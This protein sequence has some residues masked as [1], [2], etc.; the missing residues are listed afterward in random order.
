MREATIVDHKEDPYH[1]HHPFLINVT[2]LPHRYP[3][4]AI[5][6]FEPPDDVKPKYPETQ[7]KHLEDGF[8]TDY[9]MLKAVFLRRLSTKELKRGALDNVYPKDI[10]IDGSKTLTTIEKG[11][12]HRHVNKIKIDYNPALTE[13]DADLFH[14]LNHLQRLSLAHNFIKKIKGNFSDIPR[15]RLLNLVGNNIDFIDK[16]TFINLNKLEYLCLSQNP[17]K[18]VT[19]NLLSYFGDLKLFSI[20]F[21]PTTNSY[22]HVMNKSLTTKQKL[23]EL[24]VQGV[25]DLNPGQVCG[26]NAELLKISNGNLTTLPILAGIICVNSMY[27][28][29]S[30][31]KLI[32]NN[33][34]RSEGLFNLYE[35]YLDGNSIKTFQEGTFDSLQNLGIL[36]LRRNSISTIKQNYF[37]NLPS[38]RELYL[39]HNQISEIEYGTFWSLTRIE[40]LS[41][42]HNNIHKL[43]DVSLKGS[44]YNDLLLD[45]SYNQVTNVTTNFLTEFSLSPNHE[46]TLLLR[47]NKIR[48]VQPIP[49]GMRINKLDL[50]DN[51]ISNINFMPYTGHLSHIDFSNNKISTIGNLALN[52][53]MRL[54]NITLHHNFLTKISFLRLINRDLSFIDL[55][56][57]NMSFIPQK[58]MDA[59]ND[60]GN[61]KISGNPW[62][63]SCNSK[64]MKLTNFLLDNHIV[65]CCPKGCNYS[66]GMNREVDIN[67]H[68]KAMRTLP[69]CLPYNYVTL[70]YSRNFLRHLR[71]SKDQKNIRNLDVSK[72]AISKIDGSSFEELS[73]LSI[74]NLDT[75]YLRSIPKEMAQLR[76]T[77]IHI[78]NNPF[79]CRDCKLIDTLNKIQAITPQTLTCQ[80]EFE[81]AEAANICK[82]IMKDVPITLLS[83]SLITII[84]ALYQTFIFC[85]LKRLA[86]RFTYEYREFDG[87]K[88]EK[89]FKRYCEAWQSLD[90]VNIRKLI[91]YRTSWLPNHSGHCFLETI[92]FSLKETHVSII[93]LTRSKLS[94]ELLLG[95][96]YLHSDGIMIIHN[97]ISIDTIYI[98]ASGSQLT[99]KIGD[100]D[101]ARKRQNLLS[102]PTN[103]F[104]P[105][106][107]DPDGDDEESHQEEVDL[108]ASA[109]VIFYMLTGQVITGAV[110]IE[111]LIDN[112]EVELATVVLALQE[113]MSASQGVLS[114]AFQSFEEK[115]SLLCDLNGALKE[116]RRPGIVQ[117][118]KK[119]QVSV[120]DTI[121]KKAE[122]NTWLVMGKTDAWNK[123]IHEEILKKFAL[124]LANYKIT[125]YIDLL[126]MIRNILQHHKENP[127]A[128]MIALNV[129]SAPTIQEVLAYFLNLFPH[130]YPHSFCC[131]FES[132]NKDEY[133]GHE[134]YI[135][136]YQKIENLANQMMSQNVPKHLKQKSEFFVCFQSV[137][138]APHWLSVPENYA[139]VKN[140]KSSIALSEIKPFIEESLTMLWPDLHPSE[141]LVKVDGDFINNFFTKDAPSKQEDEDT[142]TKSATSIL[143]G[144]CVQVLRPEIKVDVYGVNIDIKI[145]KLLKVKSL[146]QIIFS[147][148]H[149]PQPIKV[150]LDKNSQSAMSLNKKHLKNHE[151][152]HSLDFTEHTF[153]IEFP[154][155]SKGI[156]DVF[157]KI[158]ALLQEFSKSLQMSNQT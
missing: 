32:Q 24:D 112:V 92:K 38:L 88:Q 58:I 100:F 148:E 70:N 47:G 1:F 152:I 7:I 60:I 8:L 87:Y 141:F 22:L 41:L 64:T 23:Q 51:F 140:V 21:L 72:N 42:A 57:N 16:N 110:L 123:I 146:K 89:L 5:Y 130:F 74:L 106:I 128:F 30:N 3:R 31:I 40:V 39:D 14:G 59:L 97:N 6:I 68:G 142:F 124:T 91:N 66:I 120:R 111:D 82:I 28:V 156:V 9:P 136:S 79:N 48:N 114:A 129:E 131:F 122:A 139:S 61:F 105:L 118:N 121:I 45:F 119:S 12:F 56:Y 67:C 108:H 154:C 138:L 50:S 36:S 27:L 19:Q 149:F 43:S 153:H 127:E 75:N 80:S 98:Q 81:Y 26:I 99:L 132:F 13:I 54:R 126:R 109:N 86:K 85:T 157:V 77:K 147:H 34:F 29:D 94:K 103:S 44:I 137:H 11:F 46:L 145:S 20:G 10:W 55:R 93:N 95:I 53:N 144:H 69:P 113:G 104:T 133:A 35:L 15:L 17:I 115:Q 107:H 116:L 65:S 52:G 63:C 73:N 4:L 83:L 96:E 18:V 71:F 150:K 90:H 84:A 25:S 151:F 143:E 134:K 102:V 155:I 158:Y 2:S 37:I 101:K 33:T 117:K 76:A 135:R 78:R 125:S 49:N 62:I